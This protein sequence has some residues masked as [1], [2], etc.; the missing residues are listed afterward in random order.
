VVFC[1]KD[2]QYN[3]YYATSADIDNE[4]LKSLESVSLTNKDKIK[5]LMNLKLQLFDKEALQIGDA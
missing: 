1:K 3:K 4:V 5:T 2:I